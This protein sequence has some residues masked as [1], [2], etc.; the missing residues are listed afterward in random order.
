MIRPRGQS[1]LRLFKNRRTN[2][3][4]CS[5]KLRVST[6]MWIPT[7]C[8]SELRTFLCASFRSTRKRRLAVASL[9]LHHKTVHEQ[10][11]TP[12]ADVARLSF[13]C[14]LIA[15]SGTDQCV[16]CAQLVCKHSSP[17]CLSSLSALAHCRLSVRQRAKHVLCKLATPYV[18]S[19]VVGAPRQVPPNSFI[20]Y[21]DHPP[22]FISG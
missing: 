6:G 9:H 19:K 20:H 2:W 10:S 16:T 1:C 3:H 8:R 22:S 14:V 12:S 5:A 15:M 4:A 17:Q 21:N 11:D 13:L 7:S 18:A